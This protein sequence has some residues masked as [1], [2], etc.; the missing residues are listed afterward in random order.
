MKLLGARGRIEVP[1]A[2]TPADHTQITIHS[3][4]K[5]FVEDFKPMNQYLE[6]FSWFSQCVL[7]M[8]DGQ[9]KS[10]NAFYNA[11]TIYALRLSLKKLKICAV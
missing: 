1:N 8:A 2:F 5:C 11:R 3:D 7:G 4:K 9:K 10:L 6:E